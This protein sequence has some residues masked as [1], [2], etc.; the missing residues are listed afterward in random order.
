MGFN[1]TI[2]ALSVTIR[3][4]AEL[5]KTEEATKMG[6][7]IPMLQAWGYDPFNPLEVVPEFTADVGTKQKEK[8][9][10]A[11]MKDGDPI[12]LIECK[13]AGTTLDKHGS[14]LFRYFSVCPAKIGILTN[15]IEWRFYSDTEAENKMDLTPFLTVNMT[16]VSDSQ[17]SQ[18]EKFSREAFD[19]DSL[20]PSIEALA[21]KRQVREIIAQSFENPPEE[22]IKYFIRQI[23]DGMI[24]KNV[25]DKYEALIKQGIKDRLSEMV[26]DRLQSA[27]NGT[28]LPEEVEAE[29][30]TG[31]V[32]TQDEMEGH[33][34]VQA[35]CS[36]L[37]DPARIIIRD[38]K[39]YLNILLD[40]NVRK[41]I[42]RLYLNASK[43]YIAT[44]EE[45]S[46]NKQPIENL[47]DIYKHKAQ[48]LAAIQRYEGTGEEE[49][50]S[51]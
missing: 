43:W 20:L 40:D 18:L 10:Y 1:E 3:Q 23:Y 42:C 11:I 31:I 24:T 2:A 32:T 38:T 17:V 16:E 12:I 39:S 41:Q 9:D 13:P 8:V 14:Q 26:H 48:L 7:I 51:E 37:V 33:R 22:F 29:P 36:E 6:L 45:K 27:I 19:L 44:F 4:R 15:G 35:I 25:Y 21:L 47:R 50:E 28:P 5:V 30:P 46:E 49:E 34:I